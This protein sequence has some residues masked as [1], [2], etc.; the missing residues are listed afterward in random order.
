MGVASVHTTLGSKLPIYTS[1]W[2][3]TVKYNVEGLK[4]LWTR[5]SQGLWRPWCGDSL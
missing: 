1:Y 4:C 5:R 3:L 2:Q